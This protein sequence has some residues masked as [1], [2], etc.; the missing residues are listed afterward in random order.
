MQIGDK[1]YFR[2]QCGRSKCIRSRISRENNKNTMVTIN[3]AP[4]Y[5]G[6]K[7]T[8]AVFGTCDAAFLSKFTDEMGF[9]ERGFAYILNSRG[10]PIAHENRDFIYDEVD[11]REM[12]QTDPD[13]EELARV[14]DNMVGGKHGVESFY[15]QGE[16][17]YISYHPIGNTGW[18]LAVGS[19]ESEVLAG[20]RQLRNIIFAVSFLALVIGA[21]LALRLGRIVTMPQRRR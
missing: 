18:S 1:E 5:H 14:V 21:L 4:I 2:K 9:G 3:I 13:Y 7:I 12:A 17:R 19:Y 6:N 11:F 16:K 8:G 15:F 20:A 10:L